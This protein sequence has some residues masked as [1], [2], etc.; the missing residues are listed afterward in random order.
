MRKTLHFLTLITILFTLS[1]CAAP[2]AANT[3]PAAT[4]A[5]PGSTPTFT[6]LPPTATPPPPS[7]TPLPPTATFPAA[8]SAEQVR[9]ATYRLE[10]LDQNDV[11]VQLV[12]GAYQS[13][14]PNNPMYIHMLDQI[15]IGDLNGD[16]LAD[17]AAIVGENYGG[18][19]VFVSLVVYL[20]Q[21]GAPVQAAAAGIDDRPNIHAVR[22]E[23]GQI[24]L[25]GAIHGFDDPGCCPS[26]AIIRTYRL[27]PAGLTLFQQIHVTESGAQ[28]AITITSPAAGDPVTSTVRVAGQ[29]TISPFENNLVYIIFDAQ[30]NE[31]A[32]GPFAVVS[33]GMGGPGAFDNTLDLSALPAGQTIR[34]ELHDLSMADGSTLAMTA[35]EFFHNSR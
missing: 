13:T 21:N 23:G 29:V 28:R 25:E 8:L 33:D 32:R 26:L 34:L 18:S 1:G 4:A 16:G 11:S 15:A 3:P 27:T 24:I 30:N 9:N 22:I 20:N 12:D 7:P 2:L 31:L 19:G 6:F 5:L 10:F 17:A 14:E 35:V